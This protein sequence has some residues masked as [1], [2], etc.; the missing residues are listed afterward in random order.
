MLDCINKNSFRLL[1]ISFQIVMA[2]DSCLPLP[3]SNEILTKKKQNT[4]KYQHSFSLACV[5]LPSPSSP[6]WPV[7]Y[8]KNSFQCIFA[9]Q[10]LFMVTSLVTRFLEEFL[11]RCDSVKN[12]CLL[13]LKMWFHND[14]VKCH[15]YLTGC[16]VLDGHHSCPV[17]QPQESCFWSSQRNLWAHLLWSKFSK[18]ILI[19]FFKR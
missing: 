14:D 1:L 13:I 11:T 6:R 7:H 2:N 19:Y 9:I 15:K 12:L 17:Q 10:I 16:Q 4:K 3:S 8:T 18:K 5:I